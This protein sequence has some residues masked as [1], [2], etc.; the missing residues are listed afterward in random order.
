MAFEGMDPGQVQAAIAQLNNSHQA[1]QQCQ[2]TLSKVQGETP[3]MWKGPDAQQFIANV[4]STRAAVAK[5]AQDITQ[6]VQ[7]AKSNLAAQNATSAQ[8]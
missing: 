2:Q 6:L 7:H 4:T 3:G 8:Y 1:L 5:A